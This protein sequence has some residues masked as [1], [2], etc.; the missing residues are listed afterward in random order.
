MVRLLFVFFTTFVFCY[1]ILWGTGGEA[2]PLFTN[3]NP[4]LFVFGT[5][6]GALSLAFFNYVEGV[7]KDVPKKLRMENPKAYL[8]VINA[9][10]DLKREVIVNVILVV[11]LLAVA[12]VV[13]ALSEMVALQGLDFSKWWG[14]SALSI[15]GACLFS[16]LGVMVVQAIGFVTA[17]QLRAQISMHCE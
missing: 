12:Y 4:I 15:R 10:T 7:M 5:L 17:N 6:F 16:V 8:V 11:F 3:V 13:G 14:W 9:L 1:F 2:S